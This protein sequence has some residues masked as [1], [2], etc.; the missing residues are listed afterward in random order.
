ME[1]KQKIFRKENKSQISK[2]QLHKLRLKNENGK[3]ISIDE[4]KKRIGL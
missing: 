3:F 1:S 4:M 2:E